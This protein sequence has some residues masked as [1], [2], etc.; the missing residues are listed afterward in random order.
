MRASGFPR[1]KRGRDLP[2]MGLTQ[3]EIDWSAPIRQAS[4]HAGDVGVDDGFGKIE[5]KAGNRT[6]S[7]TPDTGEPL[8]LGE[9]C[10]QAAAKVLGHNFCRRLE[11]AR[12]RVIT[13]PLPGME[14]VS[15]GARCECFEVWEAFEPARVKG[16]HARDLGLLEHDF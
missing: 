13:E 10:R 5:G 14:N 12:A 11:V 4:K 6:G 9:I 3:R 16:K 15:F 7:V 8:D 1:E 2:K